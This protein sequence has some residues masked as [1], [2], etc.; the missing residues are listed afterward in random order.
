M[1]IPTKLP[2]ELKEI[3][4]MHLDTF[5]IRMIGKPTVPEYVWWRKCHETINEAASNGN[6][7][8]LRYLIDIKDI[9]DKNDLY[10]I[11][12]LSA[13]NNHLE[14]VKYL[15]GLGTNKKDI[16]KTVYSIV[17]INKRI[18][19]ALSYS[20]PCGHL[21][22]TKY[23]IE[24]GGGTDIQEGIDNALEL[25][26]PQGKLK[27][28]KYLVRK[29][30]DVNTNGGHVLFASAVHGELEVIKYLVGKGA[31]IHVLYD[32]YDLWYIGEKCQLKLAKFLDERFIYQLIKN[33]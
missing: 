8:G 3:I 22:M 15:I 12:M 29:G 1:K 23:L 32:N 20:A 31:N 25:S 30:A 5:T 33:I 9:D 16:K 19:C 18:N 24:H 17:D 13:T 27:M 14:V 7:I 4:L 26:A 28:V 6:L 11:L 10:H 21:E 2:H